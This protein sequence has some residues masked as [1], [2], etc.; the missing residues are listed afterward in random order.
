MNEVTVSDN[1]SAHRYEA[2]MDGELAAFADYESQAG[3]LL[4][5]HTEVLPKFEGK[6][7]A[8]KL[9]KFVLAD[10]RSRGLQVIPACEFM[11]GYIRKHPEYL[12]LVSAESRSTYK[13]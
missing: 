10:A 9:A 4:L 2:M 1:P 5:P 6:G 12:D 7:V 13:L 8:S 11:A 3:A